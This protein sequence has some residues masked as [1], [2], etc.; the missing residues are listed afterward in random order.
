M[1]YILQPQPSHLA[2]TAKNLVV[3]QL[4][5]LNQDFR[6]YCLTEF[7]ELG[8]PFNLFILFNNYIV[9]LV[10]DVI[11]KYFCSDHGYHLSSQFL[12]NITS[13]L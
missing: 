8:Q 9:D 2:T 5:A 7:Q 3:I 6:R 1:G 4:V 12:M 13:V 10:Q 11:S